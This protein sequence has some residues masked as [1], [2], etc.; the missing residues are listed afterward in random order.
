MFSKT[1]IEFRLH[2]FDENFQRQLKHR[3][4][5]SWPGQN[6]EQPKRWILASTV[7]E[8]T[9]WGYRQNTSGWNDCTTTCCPVKIPNFSQERKIFNRC[10]FTVYN[11]LCVILIS[12]CWKNGKGQNRCDREEFHFMTDELRFSCDKKINFNL[13]FI[14]DG[15]RMI[16][17]QRKL[18]TFR[19]CFK[20]LIWPNS[21]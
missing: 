20:A 16:K 2:L 6:N 9:W 10:I 4:V 18:A 1:G 21:R 13:H 5:L 15:N 17:N 11:K 12:W 19:K 8:E 3:E 14:K 7:V